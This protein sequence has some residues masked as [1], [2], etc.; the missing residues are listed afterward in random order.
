MIIA[1]GAD[2]RGFELKEKIKKHFESQKIQYVDFGTNSTES[3]NYPAIASK[4]AKAVQ[5]K[6]CDCGI[7]ICGTGFGMCIVAN[8]YKGIRCVPVNNE[9]NAKLAKKHNDANILALG[10]N[11]TTEEAATKMIEIWL[12]TEFEG[13]RHKERIDMIKKIENDNMK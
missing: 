9:E 8:K 4:V 5:D 7:L 12:Q 1:I 6:S 3:V 10:A 13:N 11:Q 2:H